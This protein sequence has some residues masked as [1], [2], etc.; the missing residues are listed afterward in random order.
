MEV[1]HANDYSVTWRVYSK[2]GTPY[3]TVVEK[4]LNILAPHWREEVQQILNRYGGFK[5]PRTAGDFITCLYRLCF[6]GCSG[7]SI[8]VFILRYYT[9][10]VKDFNPLYAALI[11]SQRFAYRIRDYLQ[12]D[13]DYVRFDVR[14]I[15]DRYYDY[16]FSTVETSSA[17]L[18]RRRLEGGYYDEM[19]KLHSAVHS[20]TRGSGR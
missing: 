8:I 14:K 11:W 19:R 17:E 10:R 16:A 2:D 18:H 6:H 3:V 1:T 12:V 9:F 7:D 15:V 5:E 4:N 13:G 20:L